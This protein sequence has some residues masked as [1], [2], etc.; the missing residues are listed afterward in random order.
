MSQ[1]CLNIAGRSAVVA[2]LLFRRFE[3]RPSFRRAEAGE[4]L[5]KRGLLLPKALK[6]GM[7][8]RNLLG[9]FECRTS[10]ERRLDWLRR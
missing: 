8:E 3:G 5:G 7:K 2:P 10:A 1:R 4:L 9:R 6:L